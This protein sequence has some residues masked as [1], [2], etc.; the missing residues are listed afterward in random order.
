MLALQV[1]IKKPTKCAYT[2]I[3]NP[4]S[5][6]VYNFA[7]G[8]RG[9]LFLPPECSATDYTALN[10]YGCGFVDLF[11]VNINLAYLCLSIVF[12]EYWGFQIKLK[13]IT[14]QVLFS[15]INYG[16]NASTI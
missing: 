9:L 10:K 16:F 3:N 6:L 7:T 8:C 4:L 2:V 1:W 15:M 12:A 14:T 11:I 13:L 5:N